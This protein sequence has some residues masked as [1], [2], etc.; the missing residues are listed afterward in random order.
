MSIQRLYSFFESNVKNKDMN[1]R[2]QHTL[3]FM[4]LLY[5]SLIKPINLQAVDYYVDDTA[6]GGNTGADWINAYTDL[7]TALG[8]AT[9]GDNIYVAGGT[10]YP[11]ATDRNISFEIPSGVKIYG[12]YA[13]SGT[14]G[15]RNSTSIL[16]GNI[17][18]IGLS[19]DNSYTIVYFL[20]SS[21]STLLDGFT[22]TGGQANGVS[23]RQRSGAGIFITAL[24]ISQKC[25]PVIQ[26]CIITNNEAVSG[27]GGIYVEALFFSNSEAQPS[28]IRCDITNNS[29]DSGG[30]I[31]TTANGNGNPVSVTVTVWGCNISNNSGAY[32]GGGYS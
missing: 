20:N 14:P 13:G 6:G 10:Y 26:D 27:G 18:D 5:L 11:D 1:N 8:V 29:A 15:L 16:S 12:G 3:L 9:F 30:A 25:D 31:Y 23:S 32:I 4:A 24:G 17:N 21:A 19:S 22:I 28:I 2:R 7:Q